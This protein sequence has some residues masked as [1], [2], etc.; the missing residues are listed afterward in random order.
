MTVDLHKE[1]HDLRKE[2]SKT[3]QSIAEHAS[4][5][6]VQFRSILDVMNEMKE[7][8]KD[9][10]DEQTKQGLVLGPLAE[11]YDG[12]IFGKKLLTGTASVVIAL[13]AIGGGVIWLVNSAIRHE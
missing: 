4:A 13:A 1:I 9:I 12:V 5:D 6:S 11:A 8:L 7:Q 2:V 10:R 3:N